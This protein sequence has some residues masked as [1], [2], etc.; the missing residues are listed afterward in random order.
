MHFV[1]KTTTSTHLRS[2]LLLCKTFYESC[3]DRDRQRLERGLII[4]L[5]CISLNFSQHTSSIDQMCLY[6]EMADHH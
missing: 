3:L 6:S 2:L 4:N 5:L 1:V